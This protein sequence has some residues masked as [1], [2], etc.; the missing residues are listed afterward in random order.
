MATFNFTDNV[1]KIFLVYHNLDKFVCCVLRIFTKGTRNGEIQDYE[2]VVLSF[3]CLCF[4]L[5]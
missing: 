3:L 1:R 4:L 2:K 5:L